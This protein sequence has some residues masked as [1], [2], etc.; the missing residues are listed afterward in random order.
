MP[1]IRLMAFPFMTP[2][3][4]CLLF[5]WALLFCLPVWA[6]LNKAAGVIEAEVEGKAYA[7]T[8]LNSAYHVEVSGDVVNVR[9]TQTYHNPLQVPVHARYLFP[10]YQGAAVHAM[11]MQVGD[12][13]VEA[14][15]QPMQVAEKTFA[16]AKSAGKAASLLTQYR[17]NMFTQQIA[18]L[19]PGA[20]ITVTIEYTHLASLK[21]GQYELVLPLVV[22]PR[23]QPP[24]DVPQPPNAVTPGTWELQQLPAYPSTAGVH[25]PA[26][27]VP[28]RVQ[29]NLQL[30][31]PMPLSHIVS[32]THPINVQHVSSTQAAVSWDPVT[33]LDNK[34]F[35]LHYG[36]AADSTQAGLLSHWEADSNGYFSLLLQPPQ[37][38][39]PAQVLP[40]EMVFLL[41]C[42]GSMAGLPMLASKRFMREALQRLNPDDTFRI[43]RFSDAATEFS[44][45]PL[46][47][48]P[49]NVQ[50][51]LAYVTKLSGYGG[52]MMSSGIAQALH[53]QVPSGRVRNV[54]FLTDGYIGNEVEILKLIGR[55]LGNARLF[56]FGVGAGVNRF[57]LEEVAR[58]G[59]GFT[60]YFDPTV[61]DEDMEQ[62]TD[63]LVARLQNPVLQDITIDWG[64]LPVQDVYP[65]RIPDLYAGDTIRVTGRYIQPAQGSIE[66]TG[67]S[68][69]GLA[70]LVQAVQ[71]DQSS[72]PSLARVW[73]R[74]AVRQRMHELSTPN[75][76]RKPR[77]ADSQLIEEVTELGLAHR[78]P[79]SSLDTDVPLPQVAGVAK[80]AY[81]QPPMTGYGAPEPTWWLTL[82]AALTGIAWLRR[83]RPGLVPLV[84]N[85]T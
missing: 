22:G 55:S 46:P 23:F 72:R 32:P 41:D 26:S 5:L 52:T 4:G 54:V 56:G 48:T 11:T 69:G 8:A 81:G 38:V 42:S 6:D 70:R 65:A 34:D 62:I 17:P 37:K 80:S 76:L 57:L 39:N 13:L 60:R 36:L 27:V 29:L 14:Q 73:A 2:A 18:N 49:S 44:A 63:G 77:T 35:V 61:D 40:R 19:M 78:Q 31:M 50:L 79:E 25:I 16:Q 58:V 74:A 84:R 7:F 20:T 75:E 68:R 45:A 12:E 30:D 82:L 53:G 33:V 67:N 85:G 24:V 66:I 43:I 28:A 15:I 47:A 83:Q 21:D 9:V 51:G 10:L 59:R 64:N 3:R 1:T 71:L